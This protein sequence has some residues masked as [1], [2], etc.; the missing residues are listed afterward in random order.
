MSGEGN[1][2]V[3]NAGTVV[4]PFRMGGVKMFPEGIKRSTEVTALQKQIEADLKTGLCH[5]H[6]KGKERIPFSYR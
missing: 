4:V 1:S 3:I 2:A 6:R 5:T